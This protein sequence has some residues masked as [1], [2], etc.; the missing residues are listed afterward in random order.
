MTSR[1][2]LMVRSRCKPVKDATVS[3]RLPDGVR[4]D[5]EHRAERECMTL[6]EYI[7]RAVCV[8]LWPTL[9]AERSHVKLRVPEPEQTETGRSA[10]VCGSQTR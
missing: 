8:Y 10:P 6:S 1:A 4:K 9:E 5:A 3:V 7:R 2:R